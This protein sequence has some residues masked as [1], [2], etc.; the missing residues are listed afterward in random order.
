MFAGAGESAAVTFHVK[1]DPGKAHG[2]AMIEEIDG[3]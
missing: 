1:H 3:Q 2:L